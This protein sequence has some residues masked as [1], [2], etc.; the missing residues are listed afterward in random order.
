MNDRIRGININGGTTLSAGF[1]GGQKLFDDYE[2]DYPAAKEEGVG[3][4]KR[5]VMLTDMCEM[6]AGDLNNLI[7]ESAGR[8]RYTSIIGAGVDFNAE[9]T[10]VVAKNRGANYFSMTKPEHFNKI[11]VDNFD[12][13]FFP[14]CFDV[15][16]SVQSTT[17]KVVEGYGTPYE[18][19][20]TVGENGW[21]T[22]TEVNTAQPSDIKED[23]SVE[24][25]LILVKLVRKEGVDT[26]PEAVIN[27]NLTYKD[28]HDEANAEEITLNVPLDNQE[29]IVY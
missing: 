4:E 9:L 24:G 1:R 17:H 16:L 13:N 23:G 21:F 7:Q 3:R 20:E 8:G 28:K 5:L 25:G 12:Y 10:N 14:C 19:A 6:G 29:D 22:L 26:G 15:K 2:T 11:L 18:T 27:V